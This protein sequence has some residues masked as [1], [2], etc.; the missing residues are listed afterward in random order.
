VTYLAQVVSR[1][2]ASDLTHLFERFLPPHDTSPGQ[3]P[4]A[5]VERFL[6]RFTQAR[7]AV[8]F[9]AVPL[10]LWFSTRL[11]ASIRTALTLVYDAPRAR[12]GQHFA[13][14][15]LAGKVRDTAMVVVTV[16]LFAANTVFLASLGVLRARALMLNQN[17]PRL[18]FF[19]TGFGHFLAQLL[20]FGFGLCLFYVIYRHASPR[21]LPRNAALAA[22]VFTGLL[23]EAARRLFSW[24]LQNLA[25][26][27][28]FST[29]ASIGAAILFVLWL[30]YT[31]LVFLIGAVVAET[32]DLRARQYHESGAGG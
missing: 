9:Y 31:A 32:W 8:S 6:T 1:A 21:R 17:S 25:V 27:N 13:L 22:S 12:P 3:D 26:I 30:Y 28:R 14:A 11:F 16:I 7:R 19:L 15:Y 4:F 20:A 24:Y 5:A 18:G 29:D 2:S 23:F 10:F